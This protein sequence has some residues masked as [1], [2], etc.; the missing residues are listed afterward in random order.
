LPDG[1]EPFDF[2]ASRERIARA[3]DFMAQL[4]PFEQRVVAPM[5]TQG[6]GAKLAARTLGEPI[7]R[8]W[9][10]PGAQIASSSE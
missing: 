10:R 2:V 9:P 6:L 8:S 1:H 5:A 7:A 4:D 3:A